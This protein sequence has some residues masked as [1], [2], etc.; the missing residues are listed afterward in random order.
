M[1][2]YHKIQ[3]MFK[4]EQQKPCRIIEGQW[5][6]PE[7]AYLKDNTWVFTEKVDGTNIRVM[8]DG[9]TVKYGG[10]TD[11]AQTPM[12]LVERLHTL[13]DSK[14][15][16]FNTTFVPKE[17]VQTAVC[18]YG[19][20]YG[21]G[22]QKGGCYKPTKDFVLFD[23]KVGNIWLKREDIECIAQS[24]GIGI[25]PIVGKGTLQDGIEMVRNGFKSTWG[26]FI[27][28]GIVARPEVELNGRYGRIITKIKHCDFFKGKV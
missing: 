20:G 17:G 4:R 8:W 5:T 16:L 25:V 27:A 22:I 2:Q 21:N 28:E 11:N 1:N 9:E 26:D 23:I 7:F 18:F 19:E 13:F 15:E 24:F 10:K 6:L 12:D 14:K 3:T